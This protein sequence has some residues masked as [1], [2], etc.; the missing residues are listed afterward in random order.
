M[1]FIQH[2]EHISC[3]V[4]DCMKISSKYVMKLLLRISGQKTLLIN[5]E[6]AAGP[7]EIP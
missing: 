2:F 6:K 7:S 4:C 5:A 1:V 3:F